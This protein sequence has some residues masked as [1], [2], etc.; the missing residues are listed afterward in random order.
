MQNKYEV[1]IGEKDAPDYRFSNNDE[2]LI[3][4]T[5]VVSVDV[6]GDKLAI[7]QIIP[8][9]QYARPSAQ[10]FAPKDYD[11]IMSSDGYLLASNKV[12][13]DFRELP[14]GTQVYILKNDKL[15]AKMYSEYVEHPAKERYSIHAMSSVGLLAKKEHNGGLYTGEPVSQVLDEIIGA[16]FLYYVTPPVAATSVFGWLRKTDDNWKARDNLH[17]LMFAYGIVLTKDESGN[18]VFDFL[19]ETTPEEIY[20]KDIYDNGSLKYEALATSVEVTEH[21]YTALASDE[22]VTLFDNTSGGDLANRETVTFQE[23]PIHDL[24]AEGLIIHESNVN[25]AVVSGVGILTGKKYTHTTRIVRNEVKNFIG[26]PNVIPITGRTLVTLA[27]SENVAKRLLAFYSSRKTVQNSIVYNGQRCGHQYKLMD[28]HDDKMIGFLTSM[29]LT[30][31]NTTKA[32]C[33]WVTDYTP[34]GQ[35][36]NYTEAELIAVSGAWTA[37]KTGRH[38]IVICSGGQGGHG[39][40]G[41]A[42]S[43]SSGEGKGGAAAPGGE[44]GRVLSFTID[45]VAGETYVFDLGAGG[46]GGAV[47]A[48]GALGTDTTV[49]KDG[50]V[51]H[52]TSEGVALA[53]GVSNVFTGKTYAVPGA[54]GVAGADGGPRASAGGDVTYDGQTWTGGAAYVT[55][56]GGGAAYGNNGGVGIGIYDDG[57][58]EGYRGGAGASAAQLVEAAGLGCGGRAGNSGGGGGYSVAAGP[59]WTSLIA[60]GGSGTKGNDGGA[61][62]ALIYS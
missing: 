32:D 16:A 51:L 33:T 34:T 49:S 50:E 53:S 37:K 7:D 20:G 56:G 48:E 12:Y 6:S 4:I 29:E 24:V 54:D 46:T 8:I 10:L 5:G 58:L 3:E 13:S 27:N 18:P 38:R 60:P 45:V 28:P 21:T 26:E 57:E 30:M 11:A 2:S 39:G 9:V 17:E 22:R 23:A 61:G 14:Y 43:T 19:S 40:Y 36:N 1:Y 41:G 52:S 47:G 35:G 15:I 42:S 44:G 62:F 25:Y 59:F 31:S 55:A